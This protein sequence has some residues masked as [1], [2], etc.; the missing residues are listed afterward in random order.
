MLERLGTSNSVRQAVLDKRLFG[1][2]GSG[3]AD[4]DKQAGKTE[5]VVE[6]ETGAGD[7]QTCWIET[8]ETGS[9]CKA[10]CNVVQESTQETVSD[11]VVSGPA[12]A[13]TVCRKMLRP[14]AE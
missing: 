14:F 8:N 13:L 12:T 3:R 2:D 6:R 1:I 11:G 7:L 9:R 10:W 5:P 4:P